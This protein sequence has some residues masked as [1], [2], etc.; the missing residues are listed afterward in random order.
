MENGNEASKVPDDISNFFEKMDKDEDD[1][2]K[3]LKTVSFEIKQ[4]SLENVQRR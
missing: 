4:E 1:D 3:D 2:E